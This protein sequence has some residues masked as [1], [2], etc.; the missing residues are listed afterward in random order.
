[1]TLK[2]EGTI[3]MGGNIH[4]VVQMYVKELRTAERM[5]DEATAKHVQPLKS[6]LKDVYTAAASEGLDKK[7]LKEL[8]RRTKM[9]E[10]TRFEIDAY[11]IAWFETMV[12][13]DEEAI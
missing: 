3:T 13:D 1:M 4:K 2:D 6:H 9:D 5:I 12:A 10:A 8:L 7:C 11:E